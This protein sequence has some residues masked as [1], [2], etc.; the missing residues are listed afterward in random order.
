MDLKNFPSVQPQFISAPHFPPSLA[1]SLPPTI[2]QCRD[3]HTTLSRTIQKPHLKPPLHEHPTKSTE[4]RDRERM[5]TTIKTRGARPDFR[6]VHTSDEYE[7]ARVQDNTTSG[8][9]PLRSKARDLYASSSSPIE[10][11]FHTKTQIQ[12]SQHSA[13]TPLRFGFSKLTFTRTVTQN[14]IELH[15]QT[16]IDGYIITQPPRPST[17]RPRFRISFQHCSTTL[18]EEREKARTRRRRK[19]SECMRLWC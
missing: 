17:S 11:V 12:T 2:T 7:F 18:R 6:S 4:N 16:P 5:L 1:K 14:T 9:H 19:R 3:Q 15:H 13:R 8:Q 10:L